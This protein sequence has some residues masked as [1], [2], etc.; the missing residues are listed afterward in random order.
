MFQVSL[1]LIVVRNVAQFTVHVGSQDEVT[2]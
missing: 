2:I 1:L